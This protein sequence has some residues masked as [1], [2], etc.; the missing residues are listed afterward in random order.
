MPPSPTEDGLRVLVDRLW[1]RGISKE[2]ARI[3]LWLKELAPSNE[4]RKWYGH[5]PERWEGFKE[6]YFRE[7]AGAP[8]AVERLRSLVA[9]GPVTFVFS[10]KEE[11][12][13]NAEALK[14]Y[15]ESAAVQRSG[16]M[17]RRAAAVLVMLVLGA[18]AMAFDGKR[19][20]FVI[21][22]GVGAGIV[23]YYQTIEYGGSIDTSDRENDFAFR[24]DFKIG[25][26]FND[27]SLLYWSSRVSWFQMVNALGDTVIVTNG[28]AGIGFSYYFDA[29]RRGP[30][31]TATA[32][33]ST[34]SLPFEP[35]ASS[36]LGFG[37]AA[38]VGYEFARGWSL[39]LVGNW[40]NP[41]DSELGLTATTYAT[42]LS[43]ALC[44]L[45]Y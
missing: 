15:L 38:G 20:G 23:S 2:Q 17:K 26:G 45:A 4:L 1:P 35:D 16:T 28:V 18:V 44:G 43:L 29:G 33:F 13:N 42:G 41:S 11:R 30:Y 24:T 36:W 32:G 5:Q 21:G 8:E 7:L 6:R 14:I 37:I 40:S 27:Q 25:Y 19:Q 39:E 9:E 12:L 10:S 34:W 31:L 3:D 22:G